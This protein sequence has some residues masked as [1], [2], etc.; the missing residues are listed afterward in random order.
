MRI[1]DWS[2]DVCSSD[3]DQ[4]GQVASRSHRDGDHRYLHVEDLAVAGVAGETGQRIDFLAVAQRFQV[5]HQ[6]QVFGRLYRHVAEHLAHVEHEIGSASGRD[7]VCQYVK[8][9][10]VAVSLKKKT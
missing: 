2:S 9:S 7:N 10:V 1:S 4:H 8:I 3:L 6:A 5:D